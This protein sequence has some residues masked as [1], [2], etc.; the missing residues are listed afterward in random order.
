MII[1]IQ[2][3][4]KEIGI[5]R[6][7]GTSG[8]DI[9]KIF[10]SEGVLIGVTTSSIAILLVKVLTVIIDINIQGIVRTD[11]TILYLDKMSVVYIFLLSV[12]VITI[13]SI[14][15]IVKISREKPIDAIRLK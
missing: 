11:F 12:I 13:S 9:A 7:I 3:K 1:S 6:A 14:I 2:I 4:R 5:L 15:P 8:F 10:V